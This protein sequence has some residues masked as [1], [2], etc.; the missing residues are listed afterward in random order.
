MLP[1]GDLQVEPVSSFWYDR[2]KTHLDM[3][4][5]PPGSLGRLEEIAARLVAIQQTDKPTVERKAVFVFAAD[6]GVAAEGVS[7]YPSE[8]TEQMVLNFLRGGAAIN[9]LARAAGAEVHVVDVGVQAPLDLPGLISKKVRSGSGN[10]R[11]G[12][13]L[14]EQELLA[15]LDVG[16]TLA[17]QAHAAGIQLVATGEM[18]IAN[19]TAASAIT[20]ALSGKE[21]D[22]VTGTGTGIDGQK[23]SHKTRVVADALNLHFPS[24]Q[25]QRPDSLDVLRCVGGLEIAALTGFIHTAAWRRLAIVIDGF[26]SSAAAA[27]ACLIEPA[28]SDYLFA[29]HQS[30][31]IGHRVLLDLIGQRPLLDFDMRLGEG[32]GAVLTL[33][34]LEAA[35]RIYNEMATFASAG[36]SEAIR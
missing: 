24:Y 11:R 29:G 9:V 32:T 13:A 31:E 27:L 35:T 7:A 14:T 5:K 10:L 2:A 26:I 8:V 30:H 15:A 17:E 34:I 19:T 1:V 25:N 4:T 6:H 20:A 33:P 22:Q 12:P 3:L 16:R 18:G 21:P 36:V 23:L 28:T